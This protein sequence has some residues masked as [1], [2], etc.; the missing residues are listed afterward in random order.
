MRERERK[1]T[2]FSPHFIQE[3][4]KKEKEKSVFI[5]IGKGKACFFI[6]EKKI[7]KKTDLHTT[8]KLIQIQFI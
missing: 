6:V 5:Q 8:H 7:R 1:L 4:E 2:K 3:K